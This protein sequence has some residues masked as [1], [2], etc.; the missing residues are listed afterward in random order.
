MGKTTGF[1]DYDRKTNPAVAPL[2][3][4]QDFH[5]FHP[6]LN[7]ED[8]EEQA[9]R[10]MNCGIP[11]CQSAVAFGKGP[12]VSGCPLHNLIPEWNDE[13][14]QGHFDSARDR[15][16]KT[17]SFPEFTGRVCPALCEVAC[18]CG[19]NGDP[20]TVRE[21]ELFLIEQAYANGTMRPRVPAFRTDKKVVGS[22]PSGL[23]TADALNRR[24]HNVTVFEREDRIGGLLMYGIPNMKLEKAIIERRKALMEAEGIV[25]RTRCNVGTD[26]SAKELREE[27]D[28]VV[29][30]CGAKQPRS[31]GVGEE[32]VGNVFPAVDFLT[33][34]T[35]TLLA[36]NPM[37]EAKGKR[38]V[39]VGGGDTGNDCVGTCLQSLAGMAGQTQDRLRSGR[40]HRCVREGPESLSDD[41][42]RDP[43]E[44]K[45]RYQSG[46]NRETG[47]PKGPGHRTDDTDRGRRIGK[48]D[49]LRSSPDRGR[50]HRMRVLYTRCLWRTVRSPQHGPDRTGA[51]CH[52]CG[53]RFHGRRHASR[54]VPGRLGHRGRTV[55]CGRSR[56]V[57]NGLYQPLTG[58]AC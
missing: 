13:L 1:L 53:Q 29:L 34:Q 21:N 26:V 24:G 56:R 15:L 4:L 10:C 55:L 16:L 19:L 31:L 52:Q 39:I 17:A 50:V 49:P 40:G 25:F 45:R 35:R 20:V 32:A 41:C 44:Q 3:R 23:A 37:T 36:G 28:A 57:F 43:P 46:Q 14:Y 51:L 42:Q 9:A 5:E 11:F 6:P 2:E 12:A 18:T 8:R 38:V 27:Y 7:V 54:P 22:G 48:N 47:I 33:R 58:I 30:C